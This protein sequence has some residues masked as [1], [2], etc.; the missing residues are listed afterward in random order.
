MLEGPIRASNM[1]S[2]TPYSSTP[3]QKQAFNPYRVGGGGVTLQGLLPSIEPGRWPLKPDSSK[4]TITAPSPDR[5]SPA[6]LLY[7]VTMMVKHILILSIEKPGQKSARKT[8]CRNSATPYYC[9][10]RKTLICFD[11]CSLI[12]S[13]GF[14]AAPWAPKHQWH[15]K[16]IYELWVCPKN[17]IKLPRYLGPGLQR[18]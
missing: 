6:L 15:Y 18:L 7:I 1:I 9:S 3:K 17:I 4:L 8:L 16:A 10:N 11:S 12:S 13:F 2:I 5:K 14:F